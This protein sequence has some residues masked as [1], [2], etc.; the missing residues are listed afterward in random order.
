MDYNYFGAG[1]ECGGQTSYGNF[2]YTPDVPDDAGG[3]IW[4]ESYAPTWTGPC[5]VT[6]YGAILIDGFS[7]DQNL[8][9]PSPAESLMAESDQS[10]LMYLEGSSALNGDLRRSIDIPSVSDVKKRQRREQNRAA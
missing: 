6:P 1:N 9:P 10:E 4:Q 7:N 8:V 2:P 3:G 5:R